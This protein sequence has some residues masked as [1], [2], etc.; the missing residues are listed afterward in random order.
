MAN[1]GRAYGADP[2]EIPLQA[3][4]DYISWTGCPHLDT[5]VNTG[6]KPLEIGLDCVTVLDSPR[7]IL[8][9]Q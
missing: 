4:Y 7:V 5:L 1:F 9:T 6:F 3:I 2:S 8:D